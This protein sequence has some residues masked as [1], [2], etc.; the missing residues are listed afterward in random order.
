MSLHFETC[1]NGFGKLRVGNIGIARLWYDEERIGRT[2][3][4][5]LIEFLRSFRSPIGKPQQSTSSLQFR[6]IANIQGNISGDFFSEP[7]IL[8][9]KIKERIH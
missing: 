8:W 4:D 6:S 7:Q 9:A 5:L 2:I 1:L 3:H